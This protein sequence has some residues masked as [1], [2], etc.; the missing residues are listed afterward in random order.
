MV[1]FKYDIIS[2]HLL[3]AL[4]QESFQLKH[5]SLSNEN[6][7]KGFHDCTDIKTDHPLQNS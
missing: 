2:Y 5:L 3:I 4:Q 6:H 7:N 1:K